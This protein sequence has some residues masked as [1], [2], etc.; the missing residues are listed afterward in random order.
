MAHSWATPP[1]QPRGLR[2]HG[3][4]IAIVLVVVVIVVAV[5]LVLEGHHGRKVASSPPAAAT[6]AVAQTTTPAAAT[7]SAAATTP[8]V[9]TSTSVAAPAA[10]TSALVTIPP[11]AAPVGVTWALFQGIALPSSTS[12]GPTKVSGPIYSGYS[13]TPTGALLAAV[14][15]STRHLLTPAPG[16]QAIVATQ[17]EPGPGRDQFTKLEAA[18]AQD[19]AAP[20]GGYG[21][22]V[23]FRFVTY[24]PDVAVIEVA[25]KFPNGNEQVSTLTVRWLQGDWKQEL[26]PDGADT[27]PPQSVQNLAGFTAWSGV[28]Q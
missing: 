27:P 6:T 9:S 18:Q 20:G 1:D 16:W 15:I 8:T 17:V 24:S 10:T 28:S 19:T 14:Q 7:P 13:H 22:Y 4:V 23:G 26:Q 25:T 5:V 21:Q 3:V 2:R 11:T 12:D